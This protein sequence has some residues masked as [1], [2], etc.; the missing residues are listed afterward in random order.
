MLTLMLITQKRS[1]KY[2]FISEL[3]QI[4]KKKVDSGYIIIE[5]HNI[6]LYIIVMKI[7]KLMWSVWHTNSL[8]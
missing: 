6:L 2:K 8:E 1:Q 7:A 5:V 3:H 4:K